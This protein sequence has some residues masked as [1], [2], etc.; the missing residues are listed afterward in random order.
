MEK[1]NKINHR[2]LTWIN[3]VNPKQDDID[4]LEDKFDFHHLDFED[5]LTTNQRA[6]IDRYDDYLFLIL[7]L[8][9][10]ASDGSI[11][12]QEL[13]IFVTDNTVI[14]LH[15]N[16]G[17]L[18]E[19]FENARNKIQV[20]EN[21]MSKSPGYLVY[22]ILNSLYE[23]GFTLLD[24]LTAEA[25]ELEKEVFDIDL[26]TDKL[27]DILALKKDLINFRRIILPQR[28]VIAQLEHIYMGD[29][30]NEDLEVY[31]DNIVD[32]IEKIYSILENQKEIVASLQETNEAIIFHNTNNIIR[33]LTVFSVIMMPLSVITGFF[34]MNVDL[35]IAKNPIAYFAILI[36]MLAVLAVMLIFFRFKKWL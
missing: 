4:Y 21:L 1:I 22:T 12:S 14:T 30:Q 9:V 20:Q 28:S 5:C 27:K 13:D 36:F 31:F 18:N 35:P 17:V 6:K 11:A 24:S 23:T 32:K 10:Q 15:K 8:P 25:S 16:I 29:N 2:K 34:G 3:I 26:T 7:H 19:L 33:V